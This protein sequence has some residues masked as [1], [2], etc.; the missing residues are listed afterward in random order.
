MLRCAWLPPTFA[1]ACGEQRD[2]VG[3]GRVGVAERG[4]VDGRQQVAGRHG[5]VRG[6]RT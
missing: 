3:S 1:T 5:G 6:V 4:D 2:Q